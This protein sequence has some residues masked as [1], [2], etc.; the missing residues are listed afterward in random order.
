MNLFKQLDTCNDIFNNQDVMNSSLEKVVSIIDN[1]AELSPFVK[2][3]AYQY[4]I[5]QFN[6]DD[7]L[8][9]T[10]CQ[11]LLEQRKSDDSRSDTANQFL[12]QIKMRYMRSKSSDDQS[13]I[14]LLELFK[15]YFAN[16][17]AAEQAHQW[18][19]DLQIPGYKLFL[20]LILRVPRYALEHPIQ[21]SMLFLLIVVTITQLLKLTKFSYSQTNHE[22]DGEDIR[23]NPPTPEDAEYVANIK[24]VVEQKTFLDSSLSEVE[25][26]NIDAACRET[27]K[28]VLEVAQTD[29]HRHI[30]RV[31]VNPNFRGMVC[32]T[33]SRM[34]S[35][36]GMVGTMGFFDRNMNAVVVDVEA[37]PKKQLIKHE[38]LH[39]DASYRHSNLLCD[40]RSKHDAMSPTYPPTSENLKKFHH[41]FDQGDQHLKN[42]AELWAKSTKGERLS[43]Q[44]K[45]LITRYTRVAK[46]C[47]YADP[48]EMEID[49]ETASKLKKFGEPPLIFQ[50]FEIHNTHFATIKIENVVNYSGAYIMQYTLTNPVD[51]LL[52]LPNYVEVSLSA[53]YYQQE[54]PAIRLGE[55][56][57]Y[58]ME[59]LSP[60]AAKLIYP[61]AYD[62]RA[63]DIAACDP[64]AKAF[65]IK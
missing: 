29:H 36:T 49:K 24:S 17:S 2:F 50:N 19:H 53:G 16:T 8:A 10:A 23:L 48:F 18:T 52:Y 40:A 39:G 30:G 56:E 54:S 13:F 20:E 31:F 5:K 57:A 28:R 34:K 62:L 32:T 14:H 37:Y 4:L 38:F 60:N 43:S 33:G 15:T 11:K 9:A 46:E 3:Y 61:E 26:A 63:K 12:H 6:D 59:R 1:H 44:E 27:S 65:K 55:R 45:A 41:A 47:N 51:L 58:T 35:L 22:L 7:N 42:F 21:T 64:N 25:K